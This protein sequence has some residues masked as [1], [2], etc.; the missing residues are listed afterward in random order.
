MAALILHEQ[1]VDSIQIFSFNLLIVP[2]VLVFGF[3]FGRFFPH[4]II[5]NDNDDVILKKEKIFENT[6]MPP[7][8]LPGEYL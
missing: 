1:F 2:Y 5:I 7:I 4:Q 3:F 8:G 6:H